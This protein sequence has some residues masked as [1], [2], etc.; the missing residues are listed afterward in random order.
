MSIPERI[1]QLRK[2]MEQEGI[3]VWIEPTA[4]THQSEYL[5]PRF[6]TRHWL[7]GFSGSAG[8][9]VV[10]AEAACLWA[11]SRYWLQAAAQLEGSGIEPMRLGAPDVPAW[12]EWIASNHPGEIVVGFNGA[13]MACKQFWNLQNKLAN[14]SFCTDLD[15]IERIWS[16]RPPMPLEP[17]K[18]YDEK[19]AGESR[20]SK[21]KRL[22]ATMHEKDYDVC[23]VTALDDVAW[24]FNVRGSDVQY[25]PLVYAWGAVTS[26]EAWLFVD[27][28]KLDDEAADALC[29]DGVR[30]ADYGQV[31]GYINSISD[32]ARVQLDPTKTG[33]LMRD[34]LPDNCEAVY[35]SSP[36]AALKTIKN[37][38]E[39]DGIRRA[40]VRDGVALVRFLHWMTQNAGRIPLD[41]HTAA[42]KLTA[43]RALG[44]HYMGRSFHPIMA[45]KANGAQCH[46]A[47]GKQSASSIVD[48]GILLIDTGAQYLDGTTDVTRTITLGQPTAEQRRHFTLVLQAHIDLAMTPFPAGTCGRQL[49]VIARAPLWRESLNFGHGTGHGVGFYLN[50]HEGP[51]AIASGHYPTTG[52]PFEPGMLTSNEPGLYFEGDYGIRIESLV[53]CIE[54]E[55]NERGVFYAFE[56]VTLC[57]IDRRLIDADMLSPAQRAWLNAYHQRVCDT[58]SPHLDE[59]DSDWLA[60]QTEPL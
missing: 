25:N 51:Q 48:E 34:S 57:L 43:F 47:A 11:D 15:L 1:S 50:V 29:N 16:D 24:L 39:A 13:V 5:A 19:L 58:L 52:I 17:L 21:I 6:Q 49:D 45:Y 28:A 2:Q 33:V 4:D 54:H 22:Q 3:D 9:V 35:D 46:Y 38:A 31:Y 37:S 55:V 59:P 30:C 44:A 14:A 42:E 8:V 10:T 12:A 53:L 23:L 27:A 60:V 36:V 41:E 18:L 40:H 7:A 26:E 32:N 56:T 20:V